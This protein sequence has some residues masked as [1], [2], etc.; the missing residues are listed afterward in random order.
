L[1]EAKRNRIT[2]CRKYDRQRGGY[3]FYCPA[4]DIGGANKDDS[5]FAFNELGYQPRQTIK[6]SVRPA[7]FDQKVSAFNKTAFVQ[8]LSESRHHVSVG[9]E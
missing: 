5:H 7:E 9:V 1:N 3:D 4:C 6:P 8:S 2:S